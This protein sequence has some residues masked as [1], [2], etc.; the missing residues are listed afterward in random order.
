LLPPYAVSLQRELGL[1]VYDFTSMISLV[2]GA[3]VRV[4]FM[5]F[6]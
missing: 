6:L 1:P 2:H 5:G 3:L 4:P